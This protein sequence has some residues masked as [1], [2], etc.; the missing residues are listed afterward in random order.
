L[1]FLEVRNWNYGL[2]KPWNSQIEGMEK[3]YD[4]FKRFM[5]V[6]DK[7]RFLGWEGCVLV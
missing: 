4:I 1:Q 2:K 5:M 6:V 7:S 3:E